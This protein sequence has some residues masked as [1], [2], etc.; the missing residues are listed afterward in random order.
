MG[1]GAGSPMTTMLRTSAAWARWAL[2]GLALL[3]AP[4]A[5]NGDDVAADTE[6]TAGTGTG[7]GETSDPP[8]TADDPDAETGECL[9]GERGCPC[10]PG[11]GCDE[12]L[13][14]EDGTCEAFMPVCGDGEV[15]GDE[16]CDLGDALDDLGECKT[17]CT[18]AS[19]GDGLVG[20]GEGCDDGNLIGHD[21]CTNA[22]NPAACGD[23]VLHDGEECDDGNASDGDECTN[24]CLPA[25]CGDGVVWRGSEQCDDGNLIDT[26]AC[27]TACVSPT[28]G[29]GAINGAE[30]CD[31]GNAIATDACID[32]MAATCGDGHRWAGV[33]AC[34]G[35]ELGGATCVTQGFLGGTLACAQNCAFDTSGC[36]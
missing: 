25:R 7:S 24:A 23:A 22:C 14:C 17:D 1:W 36:M 5:C 16:Q 27:T 29:D 4:P 9:P 31:D 28:C 8:S 21:A 32:C 19:C 15:E 18:L 34:D 26:D 20:P 12:G 11:G 13:V 2:G 35:A 30:P 6:A 33:E 3:A 10:I